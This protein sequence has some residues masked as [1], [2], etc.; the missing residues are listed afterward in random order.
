MQPYSIEVRYCRGKL[1]VVANALSRMLKEEVHGAEVEEVE[2]ITQKLLAIERDPETIQTS[3]VMGRRRGYATVETMRGK[4][5]KGRCSEGNHRKTKHR[6]MASY[7]WHRM[8][9][10]IQQY[11]RRCETCQRYKATQQQA[12]VKMLTQIAEAP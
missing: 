2:W 11:V 4:K 8:H 5:P 9:R 12:A 3:I 1:N 6:I 7:Y 10:D